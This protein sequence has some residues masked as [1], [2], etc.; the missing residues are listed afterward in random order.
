MNFDTPVTVF[1]GNIADTLPDSFV[2]SILQQFGKVIR[3]KRAKND[4]ERTGFNTAYRL[5]SCCGCSCKQRR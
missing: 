5:R 3:W 2:L 4:K 1:V